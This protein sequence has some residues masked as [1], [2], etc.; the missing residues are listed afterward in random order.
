MFVSTSSEGSF[1]TSTQ[2]HQGTDRITVR[3][4][5]QNPMR[6][7]LASTVSG[8]HQPASETPFKW[9]FARRP[10]EARHH[11]LTWYLFVYVV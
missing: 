4:K 8:H 3:N 6:C 9:R 11:M 7:I 5:Y 2:P 10:M 1:V